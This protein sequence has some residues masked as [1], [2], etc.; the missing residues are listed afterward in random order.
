MGLALIPLIEILFRVRQLRLPMKRQLRK[1]AGLPGDTETGLQSVSKEIREQE[2]CEIDDL[3]WQHEYFTQYLRLF[4]HVEKRCQAVFHLH[5]QGEILMT[6]VSLTS[7]L[8]DGRQY[9]TWN[10]PLA[11][12]LKDVPQKHLQR[13]EDATSFE[14]LLAS[15]EDWLLSHGVKS[16]DCVALDAEALVER[17]DIEFAQQLDWNV[18][19][20]ILEPS[21]EGFSRYS[22]RGCMFLYGRSLRDFIR[23]S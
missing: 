6:F 16:E 15:H 1:T 11:H 10:N 2:F 5:E 23:L 19:Q 18:E 3:A 13:C 20:G 22:L 17:L 9:M 21:G 12:S 14:E 8:P 7:R 4:F